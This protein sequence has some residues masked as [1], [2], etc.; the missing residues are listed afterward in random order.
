MKE[1]EIMEEILIIVANGRMD[2]EMN[3]KLLKVSKCADS[4]KI[5]P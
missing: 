5:M 2:V 4:L 1:I 3:K